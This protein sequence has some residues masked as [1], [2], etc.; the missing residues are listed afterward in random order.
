MKTRRELDKAADEFARHHGVILHEPEGIYDGLA[1]YYYTWPGM[2]K[3]GCYGPPAYIL[4]N[5]ETGEAQWEANTDLDKY[6][7]NEVRRNLKPMPEA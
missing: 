7:S 5:V 3:G 4:V 2:A 1:L 6:I